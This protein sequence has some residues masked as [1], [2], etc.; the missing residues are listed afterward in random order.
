M[1]LPDPAVVLDSIEAFRRSKTMFTAVRLG[2]FDRLQEAPAR[3]AELAAEL[4]MNADALARLLDACAAMGLLQKTEGIY[5]NQPVAEHYLCKDS[6]HT[7]HGYIVYSDEALYPMW[8]HLD[9]ALREG[10]PRWKQ[11]FGIEGAIFSGFFRTEAAM[12]DFLRAMHGFGMQTSPA[13]VAAFDLSR[14]RTIVDLGGAT[15]HLAIA[16]CDR[17]PEM[18]GVVFDLPQVIAISATPHD[19]VEFRSGDFFEDELPKSDLYA[20]GRILHDWGEGKIHRLLARIFAALPEGGGVLI[21]EQLLE[22]DGVGPMWANMQSLNMLVTTEGRERSLSEY[23]HLLAN[24]GFKQ[25]QGR[26]TGVTL[27]AVL[28][29]R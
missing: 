14:F 7:L 19:R 16:A 9:D 23:A 24:A 25:I 6:P 3:A 11:T 21:A 10:A 4:R 18:R 8:S 22:E 26:R 28:A 29:I 5:R 17:Y 12:R 1:S 15:G 20:L 27:D 13:V 2:I